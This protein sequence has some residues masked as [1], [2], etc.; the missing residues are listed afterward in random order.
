MALFSQVHLSAQTA[1]QDSALS[2][3]DAAR[4]L[5]WLSATA[6]AGAS[7]TT[8]APTPS[9]KHF[10]ETRNLGVRFNDAAPAAASATAEVPPKE[11][12]TADMHKSEAAP[13]KAAS[14]PAPKIAEAHSPAVSTPSG[15]ATEK[16]HHEENVAR[17]KHHSESHAT[18]TPSGKS[19][20]STAHTESIAEAKRTSEMRVA[21]NHSAPSPAPKPTPSSKHAEVVVAMSKRADLEIADT[22]PLETAR[23][24]LPP[25]H[26]GTRAD[27]YPWKA[28]I[29][30]TV[31]WIGEPVGGNN[32]TPNCSSSWDA[33]WTQ[34]YGG[35]DNPNPE[36]R[37]N[38]LPVN[39]TPRQ[40]PFYVALPYN[41]VTRGTTKPEARVAIPWF[42]EAFRKEGQS[43]CRDRWV[44]IRGRSGRVAYAQWSDCG[45]F[46]TDHW[47][48]V[49]GMDRPKP[50]LNG[51]AGL[52]V[53]PAVRDYLGL[54]STD[55]T[56]WKF[57][58][59]HEVP[60][61]PWLLY[62]DNNPFAQR[63]SRGS[64]LGEVAEN[65]R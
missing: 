10:A 16:A 15:K 49:F 47:Q 33:H 64:A 9:G 31:F 45:P 25:A 11:A 42:R 28:G 59:T 60:N 32:F 5:Q 55:V 30:T 38:F 13:A 4:R 61:G 24:A 27:R 53:S 6:P 62:G 21:E 44:E 34:S 3:Q 20:A 52:D 63:H 36:A 41:D 22:H 1:G 65:R 19:K 56:D 48:Y 26:G 43:V 39:F 37:R 46:R 8:P 35:F 14:S 12:R 2:S 23:P 50:N 51:G 18:E 17:A 7:S 40:N 57:V 54:Q 58:D 29:V